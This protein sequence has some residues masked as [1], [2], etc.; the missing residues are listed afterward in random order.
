[1]PDQIDLEPH[2]Y[3]SRPE[4]AGVLTFGLLL[5]ASLGALG[6]WQTGLFF[7]W[8]GWAVLFF[9]FAFGVVLVARFP[10]YFWDR[11]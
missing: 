2:E 10:R 9:G 11:R 3:R 6:L 8:R 5:F 4:N 1:M 7:D